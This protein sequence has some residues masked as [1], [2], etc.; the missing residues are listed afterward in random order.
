MHGDVGW[1]ESGAL[2]L[3]GSVKR[4]GP[5]TPYPAVKGVYGLICDLAEVS[6]L[7]L[8]IVLIFLFVTNTLLS[9][10]KLYVLFENM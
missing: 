3:S 9:N 7:M 5:P 4:G 10:M 8:S 2:P 6:N 1:P